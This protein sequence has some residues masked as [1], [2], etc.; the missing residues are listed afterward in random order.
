VR[1]ATPL[2]ICAS[3]GILNTALEI[4]LCIDPVL[5]IPYIPGSSIKGVVRSYL[6]RA[7]GDNT[8]CVSKVDTL[9]GLTGRDAAQS[10]LMIFADS[11]PI[12]AE[13]PVV[14]YD[15]ITPHYYVGGEPVESELDAK[16]TPLPHVSI[17]EDVSFR[18]VIGL[19]P[20]AFKALKELREFIGLDDVSELIMPL[21]MTLAAFRIEGVGARTTK[22]YGSMEL[23]EIKGHP[24][25]EL[26]RD[27]MRNINSLQIRGLCRP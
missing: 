22:G 8:N 11:Y 17:P 4:G 24:D 9:L 1:T 23:S 6:S 20:G 26:V 21:V 14:L 16:P 12:E 13:Y 5:S 19:Y 25:K 7:C 3:E 18:F 27:L 15:I 2:L 10:S